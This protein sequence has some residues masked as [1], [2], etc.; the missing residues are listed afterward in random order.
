MGLRVFR[1]KTNKT[2]VQGPK[3]IHGTQKYKHVIYIAYIGTQKLHVHTY[4]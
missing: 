3:T 2:W 1:Y 4:I